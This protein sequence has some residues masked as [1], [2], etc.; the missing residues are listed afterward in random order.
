MTEQL[1]QINVTGSRAKRLTYPKAGKAII[2]PIQIPEI[3]EEMVL[4][5]NLFSGIS[6]GTESLVYTGKVPPAEWQRM[7]CPFMDGSFSFPVTYGYACVGK[8]IAAGTSVNNLDVGNTI[9]ALHPH[10]DLIALPANSCNLMPDG[11]P[12]ERG[13]LSA[14]METG[15]NAVWDAEITGNPACAVIGA[16][17]V[18]LL[19]AHALRETTGINPV[20]I[21]IDPK[22]R[23]IAEELGFRF[24][25]PAELE[26]E[27]MES[28]DILFHASSNGAGLQTAIDTAAFEAKIIEMS[29]YGDKSVTLNLGSAFHSKR[30]RI[31]SSQVGT[32]AASKR[33]TTSHADRM[34]Q[35]MQMLCDERLDTLLE[36]P[37]SFH[38]LPNHVHDIFS[39]K[40]NAL[41]P[42]IDYTD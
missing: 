41:C 3:D 22:K 11:L 28:F 14:N 35:A 2:E 32:V 42:L 29:W 24:A 23:R 26:Q 31:I 37:V 18:G 25:R 1:V 9:F 16:G 36:K 20:V 33:S 12:A 17:V 27:R 10:Q 21:D 30:L 40:S 8:V 19:T 39:H 7:Q 6:R 34:G 4:V 13:V 38:D 5:K 15:L